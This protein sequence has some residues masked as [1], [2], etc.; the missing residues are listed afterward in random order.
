MADIDIHIDLEG[1]TR[2]IGLARSNKVRGT[3]TVTFE[4]AAE[5]FADADRFS[6]EPALMLTRGAFA[7]PAGQPILDRLVIPLPIL[8]AVASCSAPSA[9][10]LKRR[11]AQCVPLP[12][13]TIC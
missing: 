10:R 4:Y 8:G 6:I 7:P 12:K 13:A 5:W 3:E 9:V 2:P 11:A 1:R